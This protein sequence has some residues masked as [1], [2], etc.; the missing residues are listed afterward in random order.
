MLLQMSLKKLVTETVWTTCKLTRTADVV[1]VA[2]ALIAYHNLIAHG[3][4]PLSF[5][6]MT[7]P[8]V[9]KRGEAVTATH[10]T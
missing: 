8:I 10:P 5:L 2:P 7:L 9:V 6:A 3:A 4:T 1:P